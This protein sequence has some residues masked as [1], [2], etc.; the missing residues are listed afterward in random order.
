MLSEKEILKDLVLYKQFHE[1]NQSGANTDQI[2]LPE[3]KDAPVNQFYCFLG[4]ILHSITFICIEFSRLLKL[5]SFV[6]F[7]AKL[8]IITDKYS[9]EPISCG[10]N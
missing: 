3:N 6:A 10:Y 9:F 8:R 2:V 5:A 7:F 1:A 4:M